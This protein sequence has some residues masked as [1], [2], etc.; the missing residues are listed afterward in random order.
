MLDLME[1]N[2]CN[3]RLG[4]LTMHPRYRDARSSRRSSLKPEIT[5]RKNVILY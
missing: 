1:Y 2:V 4:T 5:V 3:K